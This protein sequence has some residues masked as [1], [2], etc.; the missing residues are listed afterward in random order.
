MER[1]P[2]PDCGE[3]IVRGAKVCRFCGRGRPAVAR[4]GQPA[5]TASKG[6]VMRQVL[7]LVFLLAFGFFC[8]LPLVRSSPS[9]PVAPPRQPAAQDDAAFQNSLWLVRYD[10]AVRSAEEDI[11]GIEIQLPGAREAGDSARVQRFEDRLVRARARLAEALEERD[12]AGRFA[13]G[14]NTPEVTAIIRRAEERRR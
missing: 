1:A 6:W 13:A 11:R 9:G 3:L 8:L 10:A 2:C 7:G 4:A 12:A 5:D 14:E